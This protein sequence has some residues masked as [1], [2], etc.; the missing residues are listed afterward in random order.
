MSL[1][2]LATGLE[3]SFRTSQRLLTRLEAGLKER[4]TAWVSARPG[5]VAPSEELEAIAAR[6]QTEDA[7]RRKII[8]DIAASLPLPAGVDAASAHVNVSRIGAAMPGPAAQSLKR[9]ADEATEAATRVRHELA[10]GRRLLGFAQRTHES[11][12]ADLAQGDGGAGARGYDRTAQACRGIGRVG[13][14]LIDGRM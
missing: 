13:A 4:R 12:M 3:R 6:L 11:L 1:A 14:S 9:A 8:G 5:A 7:V 2:D 10:L